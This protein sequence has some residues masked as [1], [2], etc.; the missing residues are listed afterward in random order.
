LLKPVS[1]NA[2]PEHAMRAM[3][4]RPTTTLASPTGITEDELA[5][6]RRKVDG[7]QPLSDAEAAALLHEMEHATLATEPATAALQSAI[8]TA[9]EENGGHDLNYV[10]VELLWET[11]PGLRA[12]KRLH[13]RERARWRRA[14]DLL[15]ESNILLHGEA[16][17]AERRAPHPIEP[18]VPL[19]RRRRKRPWQR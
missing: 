16:L 3:A 13:E 5:R 6:M 1:A 18:A 12:V 9:R 11:I 14:N 10:E 17:P 7:G 15:R 8:D 19:E 2:D 4:Q